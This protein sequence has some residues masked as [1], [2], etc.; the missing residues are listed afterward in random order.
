M[1]ITPGYKSKRRFMQVAL[2]R[3]A[4]TRGE[5]YIA[6][7]ATIIAMQTKGLS[8]DPWVTEQL[9]RDLDDGKNGGQPVIHTGEMISISGS[10]EM[11]GAGAAAS[12][13]PFAALLQMSGLDVDTG[14]SGEVSYNR[15]TEAINELDGTIYFRWEGMYHILLAGKASLTTTGKVGEIGYLNFDVKGV[16]GGTLAGSI[17]SADFSAFQLPQEFS[18]A[19]TSF[20]LDGQLFNAVEYECAQNN[21]IELDE[22]TEVK[23]IFIDD[24]AE[25]VKVIIEQPTLGTF[26]PFAIARTNTFVPFEFTHGTD[27][28][29]IFKQA[30]AAAQILTV[31][32]GDYKGKSTWELVLRVIR[33]NDTVITTQ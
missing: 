32:P 7:G 14:T 4:D 2:K 18:K 16:Y 29:R 3:P 27:A 6:A 5:D 13:V 26:D 10:V 15:I 19:N 20:S 25:E 33:G 30:S 8:T 24:W 21:T 23:Q 31:T 28:G 12:P 9:T 1:S 17:P 11:T 22:G